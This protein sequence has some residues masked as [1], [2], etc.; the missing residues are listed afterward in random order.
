MSGGSEMSQQELFELFK[1]NER[2]TTLLTHF[3]A[4]L[5][6][7][8]AVISVVQIGEYLL[9]NWKGTYLI[10]LSLVVSLEAMVSH[11]AIRQIH[12][13]TPEWTLYRVTEWI[14]LL[15]GLK[16]FLYALHGFGQL[17]LDLPLWR[18]D[19]AQSFFTGEYLFDFIL[20]FFVWS[21]ANTFSGELSRLEGDEKVL[22]AER[23]T[24]IIEHRPEVRRSLANLILALGAGMVM[25]AAFLRLDWEALWGNRAPPNA[26]VLNILIYFLLALA[27]LSLTQFSILRV[28]W[29]LERVPIEHN[30]ALRWLAYAGLFL[31]IMAALAFVLPTQYSVGL[32]AVLGYLLNLA[33]TLISVIGFLLTLPVIFLLAQLAA[34]LG[35]KAPVISS[36]PH[37]APPPPALMTNAAGFPEILKSILF[38]LIFLV[39]I[40]FSIY[41]FLQHHQE[42]LLNLRRVPVLGWLVIALTNI[43]RWLGRVNRSLAASL[44]SGVRRFRWRQAGRLGQLRSRFVSLRRLSPRQKVLFYYLAMIRRSSE[45][46]MPRQPHQTPNEYAQRLERQ[47]PEVDE[48]VNSITGHFN[49]ARYSRHEIT[50]RHVGQVQNYWR[51]IRN[52]LRKTLRGEW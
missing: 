13:F 51:H 52:A 25:L 15:V 1:R 47:L 2:L 43:R 41:S 32:L 20:L 50:A 14:T 7:V 36:A 26:D 30:L 8:C 49:E 19:F 48:D 6:L 35:T 22:Q 39:V 11:R 18:Q 33:L 40:G 42:L 10:F 24:G 44:E 38:W 4:S 21:L 3:I 46:G 9:P 17:W 28:R 27:L 12:I 31:F 45:H 23:E 37:P 29:I 5:M 34:L 16:L